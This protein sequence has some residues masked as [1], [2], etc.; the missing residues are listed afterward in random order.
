MCQTCKTTE[1]A[2]CDGKGGCG[3]GKQSCR[4]AA[5]PIQRHKLWDLERSLHCPVVGTCLTMGELRTLAKRRKIRFTYADPDDYDIHVAFVR[6]AREKSGISVFMQK[7]LDKRHRAAVTRFNRARS[8]NDLETLWNEALRDGSVAGAFWALV[9]HPAVTE[10]LRLK[11]Y[12]QVHMLS[13]QIGMA[14]RGDLRDL[15]RL[16]K[17]NAALREARETER[18]DFRRRLADRDREIRELRA[19]AE[20]LRTRT[21][22]APKRVGE[23]SQAETEGLRQLVEGLRKRLAT[24]GHRNAT[25]RHRLE[26]HERAYAGLEARG[27]AQADDLARTRAELRSL[28]SAWENALQPC[29][30]AACNDSEACPLDLKGQCILYVGGRPN[31]ACH[32]RQVVER[33]NGTF[34]YH[35][36]GLDDGADRLS[37]ALNQADAVLFPISCISHDATGRIRKLC[38]RVGTPCVPIRSTGL[39][40]FMDGLR[41]AGRPALPS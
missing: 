21:P 12:G 25:L 10:D 37:G 17:E 8:E 2:K 27:L 24:S 33:S 5:L 20:T 19:Q 28:E 32:F 34:L 11:A 38:E 4:G 30:K 39:G 40:S 23:A 16:E 3:K 9:T 22:D 6:A 36:G 1:G 29:G 31:Q 7:L 26:E 13:H 18:S 35:D 41:K 14:R 15:A